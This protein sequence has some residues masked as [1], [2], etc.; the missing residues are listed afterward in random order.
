MKVSLL[1]VRLFE[2]DFRD[3]GYGIIHSMAL[4]SVEILFESSMMHCILTFLFY[5]RI[6]EERR[7]GIFLLNYGFETMYT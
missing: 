7:K 5:Y 4:N 3:V 1:F 6:S 2:N